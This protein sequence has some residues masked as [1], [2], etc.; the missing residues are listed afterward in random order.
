MNKHDINI[1]SSSSHGHAH[2]TFGFS[3]NAT[4]TSSSNGCLI[5]F[6]ASYHMAKDKTIFSTLNECNTEKICVDDYKSLMVVGSGTIQVDNDHFNFELGVP[7][8]SCNLLSVYQ[9]THSG[10]HKTVKFSPH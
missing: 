10:E 5:D 4:S 1:D 2:S 8:I 3:F 7:S 6:G 9:I